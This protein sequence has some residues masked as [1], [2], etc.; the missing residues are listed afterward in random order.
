MTLI[1]WAERGFAVFPLMPRGK[2][3]LGALVPNGFKGATRDH[4]V[5][6]SWWRREPQANIGIATGG[7]Y[8]IVDLD[9][10]E[11]A[12]WFGESCARTGVAPK[13]LTVRTARGFHV[14]FSSTASV[15]NSAGRIA[16][17]IDVRGD[18]GYVVGAPS[19]HPSGHVY[20]IVRD[21]P[22]AKAPGWLVEAAMPAPAPMPPA[23]TP[24][25]TFAGNARAFE[26]IIGVV[27]C[28]HAGRRND[29]L[30]WGALR[31]AA[32]AAARVVSLS[33]GEACLVEAAKQAGLPLPEIKRTLASAFQRGGQHG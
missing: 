19:V 28:A 11:A 8:F 1:G 32:M 13:T 4:D 15:P 31:I 9:G 18:G 17:S 33:E 5:I 25:N 29:L 7:K 10:P 23:Y 6:T 22:I 30:F 24:R 20:T 21:L 14:F 16:P 2:C 3:P 12:T 26:G 27:A